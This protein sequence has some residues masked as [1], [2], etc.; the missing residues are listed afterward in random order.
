[1]LI[2]IAFRSVGMLLCMAIFSSTPLLANEASEDSE[3][4]KTN[5]CPR[6]RAEALE[7]A[8]SIAESDTMSPVREEL[9]LRTSAHS[10]PTSLR[11]A[12]GS[13]ACEAL[14]DFYGDL[15]DREGFET[16]E[17]EDP[18]ALHLSYIRHDGAY[19]VVAHRLTRKGFVSTGTGWTFTVLHDARF[20][21]IY[22]QGYLPEII[23]DR[24]LG[25]ARL[26]WHPEEDLIRLEESEAKRSMG[27]RQD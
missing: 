16:S 21:P 14:N 23:R 11:E 25:E 20:R 8:W 22:Y 4:E 6:A 17:R 13:S 19:V 1:M 2:N 5:G 26:Y 24:V 10:E 27:V 7:V 9:G 18:R 3:D 12:N 15:L